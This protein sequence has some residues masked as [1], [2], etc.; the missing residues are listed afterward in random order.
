MTDDDKRIAA[1]AAVSEVQPGMLVGLGTG[2]TAAFAI[3]ALGRRVREG[4]R[5]EAVATSLASE[6]QAHD[7]GIP[8]R[9][10]AT[11]ASVDLTIDGADEID[12]DL[13]A[14]KGAGGA[15]L[16]EKVVAAASARMVVIADGSKRVA[17]IGGRAVPVEIV[18]FAAAFVAQALEPL[19]ASVTLRAADER[20]YVTDNG[21]H[22]L[23][24]RSPRQPLWPQIEAAI[25]AIS[26]I[27]GHGLFLHQV[28]AAYIADRGVVSRLERS[29]GSS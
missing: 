26:G 20:P 4:L 1:E 11:V 13:R 22:I 8:I 3:Q 2:T 6:R 21:N 10:F 27:C 24:C 29:A 15:M 17:A 5:I 7:L 9:D 23:D 19:F 16:R 14:I 12:D 25:Q 28:D 18:P